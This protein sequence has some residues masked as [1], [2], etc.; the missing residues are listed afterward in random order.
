M[1]T[2]PGLPTLFSVFSIR[3]QQLFTSCA[4]FHLPSNYRHTSLPLSSTYC[5]SSQY[6]RRNN[7]QQ[8]A[9]NG[10]SAPL[11]KEH[12]QIFLDAMES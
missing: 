6:S 12:L 2:K 7:K 5:T 10:H 11:I 3:K 4:L 8:T 9:L 1:E